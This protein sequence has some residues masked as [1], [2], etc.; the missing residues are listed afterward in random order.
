MVYIMRFA[1]YWVSLN[2]QQ[3]EA[4]AQ[5]AGTTILTIDRKY[6]KA[7]N[8]PRPKRMV[9]LID[10]TEGNVS[11]KEMFDHFYPPPSEGQAA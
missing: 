2:E 11:R 10:A 6:L 4:F 5:R 1:E 7:K 3:Q 9:R 8:V